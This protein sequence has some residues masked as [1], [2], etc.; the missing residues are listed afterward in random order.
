MKKGA[1]VTRRAFDQFAVQLLAATH[2]HVHWRRSGGWLGSAGSDG[3]TDGC[4]GESKDDG[5]HVF[6]DAVGFNDDD[7]LSAGERLLPI[8]CD[9]Y[10]L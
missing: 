1:P 10:S 6:Q 7:V 3:E 5:F 8:A 4:D 9:G 2:A